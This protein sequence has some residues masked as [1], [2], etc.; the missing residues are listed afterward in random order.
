MAVPGR[1]TLDLLLKFLSLTWDQRTR[2]LLLIPLSLV[3]CTLFGGEVTRGF[4]GVFYEA[5]AFSSGFR[6]LA[7]SI[8]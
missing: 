4:K 7:D 3:G 6:V 2:S 1:S 5:S 8:V